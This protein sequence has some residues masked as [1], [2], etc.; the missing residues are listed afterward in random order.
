MLLRSTPARLPVGPRSGQMHASWRTPLWWLCQFNS[1][2]IS[3]FVL[4]SYLILFLTSCRLRT[5]WEKVLC[6]R[7][8]KAQGSVRGL[9]WNQSWPGEFEGDSPHFCVPQA[10]WVCH[11]QVELHGARR[12]FY[13][14][15]CSAELRLLEWTWSRAGEVKPRC[16][17]SRST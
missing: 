12:W 8:W 16:W 1:Y 3:Q 15:G 4:V 10:H 2:F 7:G 11:Q 13:H 14:W 9:F 6:C 5:N 17:D